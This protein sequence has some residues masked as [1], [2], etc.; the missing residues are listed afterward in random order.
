MN[1]VKTR[2]METLLTIAR[3]VRPFLAILEG[4]PQTGKTF[5]GRVLAEEV[6]A[7]YFKLSCSDSLRPEEL[8][9]RLVAPGNVVRYQHTAVLEA[10]EASQGGPAVLVVDEFDK[11]RPRAEDLFLSAFE[12]FEFRMPTGEVVRANPENLFVVLAS[13]GRRELRAE[14]LRRFPYRMRVGFPPKPTQIKIVRA[15]APECPPNVADYLVRLAEALRARDPF[16]APSY[17]ELVALYRAAEALDC[18]VGAIRSLSR[19]LWKGDEAPPVP[20]RWEKGL[21]AEVRKG[22]AWRRRRENG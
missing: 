6:G 3:K 20:W 1:A 16:A 10:F 21:A 18:D 14:T 19:T 11:T 2:W 15:L 7:A 17:G 13:N 5:F 9:F 22:R 4:P 12:D 8:F